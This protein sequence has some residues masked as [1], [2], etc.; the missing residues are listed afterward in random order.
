MAISLTGHKAQGMTIAKDEPFEKVVLHFPTS[1][2][3][4]VT[5]GLEYVMTGRAKTLTDFAIGNKVVVLDRSK[6]LKIG[7]MPKDVERREFQQMVKEQYEH[8]DRSRGKAEIAAVDT[9]EVKTY[10]GGCRFLRKWYREKF[11]NWPSARPDDW[12]L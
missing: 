1:A 12:P 11:W 7:T 3:K 6:L 9:A 8:V 4:K 5:V 2:T 10:K